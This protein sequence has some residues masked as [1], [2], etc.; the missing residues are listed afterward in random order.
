[1]ITCNMSTSLLCIFILAASFS[2]QT[3]NELTEAF[4]LLI[5]ILQAQCILHL[6]FFHIVTQLKHVG[7]NVVKVVLCIFLVTEDIRK[8]E[9]LTLCTS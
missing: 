7:Q 2:E 4:L 6:L 8:L 5:S 9:F 1:M 3:E